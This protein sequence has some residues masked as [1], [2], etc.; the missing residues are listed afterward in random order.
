MYSL[1]RKGYVVAGC[2]RKE[3]LDPLTIQVVHCWAR[4]VRRCFLCG[5]DPR[6]GKDYTFR[7]QQI[8]SREKLLARLFAVEI[9]FHAE[10]SNH[11]HLV[12][13]NRP[14]IVQSWSDEEVVRRWKCISKLTRNFDDQI[15]EP[16]PNEIQIQAR[17]PE[18]VAELRVRLSSISHFMAAL[19]ENTARRCNAQDKCTGCFWEGRFKCRVLVDE[20]AIFV[21]GIYVDLNEIWAGEANTPEESYHTSAYDRIVAWKDRQRLAASNGSSMANGST[22]IPDPPLELE[23]M[24]ADGWL[25]PLSLDQGLSADVR[26]GGASITPWRASDKGLLPMTLEQYLSFLDH[27]GRA[28]RGDKRNSIPPDLAPILERLNL[29]ETTWLEAIE[30]FEKHAGRVFG[31]VSGMVESAARAGRHWFRGVRHC[32]RIFSGP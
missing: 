32:A 5:R 11:L 7:R 24:P 18:R 23:K 9:A 17:D 12:L 14:D 1:T 26:R 25:C 30:G 8:V 16:S 27:A 2:A 19:D 4:C 28:L 21:C 22:S 3:I 6:T 15:I 31:R 13:R 10:L 20:P 29:R